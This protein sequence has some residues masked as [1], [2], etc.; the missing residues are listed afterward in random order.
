MSAEDF[1]DCPLVSTKGDRQ[2]RRDAHGQHWWAIVAMVKGKP[3]LEGKP[4]RRVHA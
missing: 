3:V 2:V 4:R 1:L